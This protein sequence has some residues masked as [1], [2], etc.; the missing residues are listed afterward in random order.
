MTIE[1]SVDIDICALMPSKEL[2][3]LLKYFC[4]CRL[5]VL[6]GVAPIYAKP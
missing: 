2:Q 1:I 3:E 6:L 4:L 5:D